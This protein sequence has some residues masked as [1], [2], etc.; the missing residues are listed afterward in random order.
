MKYTG[1][2]AG[3]VGA[4]IG[5]GVAPSSALTAAI[6]AGGD[7]RAR[8]VQVRVYV[9]DGGRRRNAPVAARASHDCRQRQDTQPNRRADGR[10]RVVDRSVASAKR[11][12]QSEGDMVDGGGMAAD[13]TNAQRRRRRRRPTPGRRNVFVGGRRLPTAR[14]SATSIGR[15]TTGRRITPSLRQPVQ[16]L[17]AGELVNSVIG[18]L[19]DPSSSRKTYASQGSNTTSSRAGKCVALSGIATGASGTTARKIYRTA[20]NGSQLKLLTT[21]NDNTTTAIAT[22]DTPPTRRSAPTRRRSIPQGS[23]R[24]AARCWPASTSII[25]SSIGP[26]GSAGG[27][28]MVANQVVRYTGASRRRVDRRT[29]HRA[30]RVDDVGQLRA[31]NTR[32]AATHRHTGERR[33]RGSCTTFCQ[34]TPLTCSS[35][36]TTLARKP[37]SPRYSAATASSRNTNKIGA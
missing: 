32:R 17:N 33:R 9:G 29:G 7:V 1:V 26:F 8:H 15:S 25:V 2:V 5:P 20:V 11:Q 12:L 3:G 36:S 16:F 22:P 30:R 10:H 6:A 13:A 21:I 4:F 37:R 34:A 23:T 19:N 28:A 14:S 18:A 24:R 27:W 35:Y 31:R